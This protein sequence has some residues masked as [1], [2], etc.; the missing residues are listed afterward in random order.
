M[1]LMETISEIITQNIESLDVR[2]VCERIEGRWTIKLMRVIPLN[3]NKNTP[4][5]IEYPFHLFIR[6]KMGRLQFIEFIDGLQANPGICKFEGFEINHRKLVL[7]P[8]ITHVPGNINWGITRN[9][10]P[11]WQVTG[12]WGN[13]N[14]NYY[15]DSQP[16]ISLGQDPYFP[17][18]GDA[19]AWFLYNLPWDRTKTYP[20]VELA[21]LDDRAYFEGI[22]IEGDTYSV[23]CN[24]ELLQ[25][26]KIELFTSAL[27]LFNSKAEKYNTF[28]VKGKPDKISIVLTSKGEW[29]DRRDVNL[30]LP[31]YF[32]P[33]DVNHIFTDE[34]L[35]IKDLISRRGE[36]R[37]LEFKEKLDTSSSGKNRFLQTIVAFANTEGGKILLGVCDDS[38]VKGIELKGLREQVQNI[39]EDNVSSSLKV[40]LS[41]CE[42]DGRDILVIQVHEGPNK[43]YALNV[44]SN[45]P[46]FY[47]RRDASNK[48]AKPD[49][50][51]GMFT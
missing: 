35:A 31:S 41:P 5:Y 40:D 37:T 47:I 13:S 4:G 28:C 39:I 51:K 10:L 34:T 50:I 20:T 23:K 27:Q 38:T 21:I 43:P 18:E 15:K 17:S 16:L 3:S 36:S 22:D 32:D 19:Q 1:D 14:D 49:D 46:Q 24:G 6:L 48:M 26:C 2:L 11:L 9:E 44:D 42:I 12:N 29:L 33:K 8:S 30:V 25:D 7:Y 45:K